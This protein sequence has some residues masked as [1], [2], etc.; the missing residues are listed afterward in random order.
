MAN[1][2]LKLTFDKFDDYKK[3]RDLVE[4]MPEPLPVWKYGSDGKTHF[5]EFFNGTKPSFFVGLGGDME[6]NKIGGYTID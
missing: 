2:T 3:A 6:K 4:S 1:P 5:I